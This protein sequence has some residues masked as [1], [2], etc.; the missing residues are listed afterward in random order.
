MDSNILVSIVVPVY[1]TEKYLKKCLDSI[2]KQTYKNIEV[3]CVNDG[4]TDNSAQILE[5][6]KNQDKRLRVLTQENSGGVIA[7]KTG[8]LNANGDYVIIEDSDDWLDSDLVESC[9]NVIKTEPDAD[10]VKFGYYQEPSHKGFNLCNILEKTK[11]EGDEIK[12]IIRLLI[13]SQKCNHLW[14]EMVKKELF[15]FSS[16]IFD[17][18]VHKGEDLQINLQLYT[19]A[20]KVVL[21][22][23]NMYHY[24]KN[25]NGITGSVNPDKIVSIVKDAI[26]LNQLRENISLS[27]FGKKDTKNSLNKILYIVESS[28]CSLLMA[29]DDALEDFKYLENE[30]KPILQEF[31]KD[32]TEADIDVGFF[33]RRIYR[34]IFNNKL[35]KNVKYKKRYI[36]GQKLK[37][38]FKK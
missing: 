20:K 19:S 7:R 12:D 5:E 25:P 29:K 15:D 34:N 16:E 11:Y 38:L 33:K 6:Y 10:I 18:I 14:N 24:L 31:F 21:I 17:Y 1:N 3:I 9:V 35:S 36:A 13:Y 32:F 2:L 26:Y 28:T 30:L 37:K 27:F 8:V 4:S 22:D 23:K